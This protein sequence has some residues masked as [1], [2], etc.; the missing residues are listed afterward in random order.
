MKSLLIIL[1]IHLFP[2]T[3]MSV[4][5]PPRFLQLLPF[6]QQAPDQGRT[7]TCLYV[8]STGAMELIANKKYNIKNPKPYGP[9]DFSESFLISQK[10]HPDAKD[11]LFLEKVVHRF[12][13]G[14]GILSREWDFDVWNGSHPDRTVWEARDWTNM[15]KVPVPPIETI[16]LFAEGDR[17]ATDVLDDSHVELVKEALWEHRSPVLISYNDNRYWHVIMVVGY[18]DTVPGN[19]YQIPEE[20][21]REDVGSF[22]VRDSFGLSVELRDYDWFRKK[23]NHAAVVKEVE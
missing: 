6:V 20:E 2:N 8:A 3:A 22:Y 12:N 21:C 13:W 18:D 10:A 9:Y 14:Y 1:F 7:G 17:W 11:K 19:C 15:T 5:T 4:T 16:P 23:V